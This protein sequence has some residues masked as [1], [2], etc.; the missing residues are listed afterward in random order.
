[1]A[2]QTAAKA[3]IYRMVMPDH[4]C[5]YGL[6]AVDLLKRNGFEVDDRWLETR[7]ETDAFK[8]KHNIETT[9]QTF[10]RGER[11]G[12]YD[13]LRLHRNRPPTTP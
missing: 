13:D 11:I 10:I 2:I 7:E 12:G 4:I 6:K 1:M 5:P 8:A 3:T 9:P